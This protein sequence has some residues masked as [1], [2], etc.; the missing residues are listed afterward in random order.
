MLTDFLDGERNAQRAK[1]AFLVLGQCSLSVKTM[2]LIS[3]ILASCL[4]S[5]I[6]H[7]IYYDQPH[8][9]LHPDP[10]HFFSY[11]FHIPSLF[12]SLTNKTLRKQRK[13]K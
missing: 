3:I 2:I 10:P 5:N 4:L 9:Q 7:Q 11:Q 1:I 13:G 8:P 12:L 6:F